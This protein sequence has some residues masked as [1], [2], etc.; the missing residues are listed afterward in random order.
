MHSLR[1]KVMPSLDV[2][3]M[4]KD[5]DLSFQRGPRPE[6]QDEHRPDHAASLSHKTETLRDSAS[7]ASR[8]R[9]PTGT[10]AARRAS[11]L[12]SNGYLVN[13]ERD[14]AVRCSSSFLMRGF[15][16]YSGATRFRRAW[17]EDGRRCYRD[18][19]RT[20]RLQIPAHPL[21][22]EQPPQRG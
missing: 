6:P 2:K 15:C 13:L 21:S 18:D 1:T 9:F 22:A 3:L 14:M 17:S 7:L 12:V 16:R 11:P 20:N 10:G 19:V 4:T 5:Q 8:I